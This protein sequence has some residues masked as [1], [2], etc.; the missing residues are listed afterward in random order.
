MITIVFV[1]VLLNLVL[2]VKII[3]FDVVLLNM[4]IEMIITFLIWL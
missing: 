4:I 3:S 1:C 2:I